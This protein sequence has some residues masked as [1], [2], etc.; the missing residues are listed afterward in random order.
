MAPDDTRI[1]KSLKYRIGDFLEIS[2]FVF[3]FPPFFCN[4][5]GQH[6]Q[7]HLLQKKH[8][9]Q[10]LRQKINNRYIEVK[11]FIFLP[12]IFGGNL[13]FAKESALGDSLFEMP[14]EK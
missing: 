7:Q 6:Q 4:Q 5:A 13:D 1:S 3:Q 2:K 9:H 11:T 14:E 8:Q 12:R 10:F